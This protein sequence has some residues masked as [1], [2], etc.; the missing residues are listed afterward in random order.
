[1]SS[2]TGTSLVVIAEKI[3]ASKMS[4]QE[5]SVLEALYDFGSTSALSIA[6]AQTTDKKS[7]AYKAAMR[8]INFYKRG[9]RKPS[10]KSQ[11]QILA[12]LQQNTKTK[13]RYAAKIGSLRVTIDG[14][15]HKSRDVRKRRIVHSLDPESAKKFLIE[16]LK[17]E[18]AGMDFLL[19][20]YGVDDANF[21]NYVIA[22]EEY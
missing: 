8:K 7:K 6:L 2:Y 12:A 10:K 20:D 15:W 19:F 11:E 1:M 21:Q 22:V 13:S 4:Y 17:S 18:E 14:T 5:D 16:I 3:L 9:A